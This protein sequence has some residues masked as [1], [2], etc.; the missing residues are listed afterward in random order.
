PVDAETL[1]YLRLT[2]RSEDQIALVE[3]YYRAQGMFFEPGAPE[4]VY[5]QTLSLDLSTVEPSVAG[6]KRPQDRVLLKDAAASFVQQLPSLLSPTAKPL[7][8]RTAAAWER[9]SISDAALAEENEGSSTSDA[10]Q[11]GHSFQT[12]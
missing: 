4:A 2:G 12:G 8:T 9:V 1:R 5:S 7:G 11:S 6:P 3:A 10:G